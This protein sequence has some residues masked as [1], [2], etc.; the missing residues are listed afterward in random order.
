MLPFILAACLR[1]DLTG[2][3]GGGP[4]SITGVNLSQA[5]SGTSCANPLKVN[6]SLVYAGSPSGVTVTIEQSWDGGAY[7][8]VATGVSPTAMPYLLS[9]QGYYDKFGV[10]VA[11]SVRVT[12]DSDPLDTATSSAFVQSYH[13]CDI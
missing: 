11:S 2:G 5:Q 6:V 13:R 10:S 4:F 3:G 12:N 9:M 1:N 7:T 8:T